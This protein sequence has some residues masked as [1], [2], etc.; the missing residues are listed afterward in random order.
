MEQ[1]FFVNVGRWGNSG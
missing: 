1:L